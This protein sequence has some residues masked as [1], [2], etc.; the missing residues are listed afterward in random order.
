MEVFLIGLLA[1][2]VFAAFKCLERAWRSR[3]ETLQRRPSVPELPVV[4]G[5]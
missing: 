4:V 5:S 1:G 2:L 3:R